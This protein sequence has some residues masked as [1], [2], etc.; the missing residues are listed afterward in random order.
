MKLCLC[1]LIEGMLGAES[2]T[3][4]VPQTGYTTPQA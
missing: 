1:C 3:V 2:V 4:T